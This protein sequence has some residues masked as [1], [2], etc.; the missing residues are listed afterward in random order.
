MWCSCHILQIQ[1]D[2]KRDIINEKNGFSALNKFYVIEPNKR[3]FSA[4]IFVLSL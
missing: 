4:V 1:I 2:S 3:K